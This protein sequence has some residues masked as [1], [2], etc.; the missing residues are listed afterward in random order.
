MRELSGEKVH[1][2]IPRRGARIA[3]VA[4]SAVGTCTAFGDIDDIRVRFDCLRVRR[5]TEG[6][7]EEAIIK[8][9]TASRLSHV[10][11]CSSGSR[12]DGQLHGAHLDAPVVGC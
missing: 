2:V 7:A 8:N 4:G 1:L 6:F 5:T 11:Y 10:S 9:K 3:C 12:A